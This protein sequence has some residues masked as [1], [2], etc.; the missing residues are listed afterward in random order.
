MRRV[1]TVGWFPP[2][3]FGY[4]KWSGAAVCAAQGLIYALPACAA[5]GAVLRIDPAANGGAGGAVAVGELP[6]AGSLPGR[7]HM[8]RG[9]CI[10]GAGAAA[11]ADGDDVV[12]YGIPS[13]ATAVL[14]ADLSELKSLPTGTK[15]ATKPSVEEDAALVA[16]APQAEYGYE[17]SRSDE[18][19]YHGG[20]EEHQGGEY[21]EYQEGEYDEYDDQHYEAGDQAPA[22]EQA[23]EIGGEYGTGGG[24]GY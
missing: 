21:G 10:A 7:T 24:G 8:W 23:A 1:T 16:G 22:V 13:D 19:E 2:D 15:A 17:A 11:D 18:G 3:Q 4:A 5:N 20:Y 12:I 9:G 6:G 14:L